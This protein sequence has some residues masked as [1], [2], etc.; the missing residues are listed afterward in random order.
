M[1]YIND[2][3]PAFP[4]QDASKWQSHGMS[5]RALFAAILMHAELV[6]NGV[7]GEACDALIAAC[8][9]TGREPEDQ[10][11]FNAVQC[12]DAL[13]RE[14]ANPSEHLSARERQA[15]EECD[16]LRGLLM[17]VGANND[18]LQQLHPWLRAEIERIDNLP[19]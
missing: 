6:T 14:L 17:Q 15:N 9:A 11:A 3:G 19:F 1:D 4:V 8:E 5:H 2:G 7:P 10:M 13:V 18:A 16:R 12:A